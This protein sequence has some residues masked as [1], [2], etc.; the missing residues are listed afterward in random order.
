MLDAD[1]VGV[2]TVTE[3]CCFWIGTFLMVPDSSVGQVRAEMD[4]QLAPVAFLL[5]YGSYVTVSRINIQS[6]CG[7]NLDTNRGNTLS[8]LCY[9]DIIGPALEDILHHL[10]P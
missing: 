5:I 1:E 2:V 8:A 10:Y 4:T 9:L 7:T 3:A 6:A